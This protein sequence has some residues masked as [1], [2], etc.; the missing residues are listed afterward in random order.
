MQAIKLWQTTP[1]PRKRAPRLFLPKPLA[2]QREPSKQSRTHAQ[3]SS[4][5]HHHHYWSD[6]ASDKDEDEDEE[7]DYSQGVFSSRLGSR[8]CAAIVVR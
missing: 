4:F 7:E 2:Q 3:V 6:Q 5:S 1:V 8:S